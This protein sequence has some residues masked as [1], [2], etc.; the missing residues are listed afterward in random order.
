VCGVLCS[1]ELLDEGVHGQEFSVVDEA[2]LAYEA[3]KRHER[4][5]DTRTHARQ[6]G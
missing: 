2:V 6:S 3:H 5:L 1:L 4:R